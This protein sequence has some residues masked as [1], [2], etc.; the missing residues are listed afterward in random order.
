MRPDDLDM[1]AERTRHYSKHVRISNVGGSALLQVH[2][3]DPDTGELL[4]HYQISP[5]AHADY[6]ITSRTAIYVALIPA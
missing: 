5:G 6:N 2:E 1:F 4:L 3:L